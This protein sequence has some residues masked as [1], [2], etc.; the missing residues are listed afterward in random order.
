[1]DRH[2]SR[3]TR[4]RRRPASTRSQVRQHTAQL[5]AH[6]RVS[7]FLDDLHDQFMGEVAGSMEEQL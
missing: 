1:M 2:L 4:H 6:Y 3:L 5:I 7:R